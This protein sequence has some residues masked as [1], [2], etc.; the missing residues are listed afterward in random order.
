MYTAANMTNQVCESLCEGYSYYGTEYSTECFCGDSISNGANH[1]PNSACDMACGGDS[2]QI[3]G[4]TSLLS[5][6]KSDFNFTTQA[7]LF[8]YTYLGCASEPD[9]SRALTDLV[10]VGL[11][12][13]NKCLV[14]CSYGG[15]AYAGMEYGREC[16]CGHTLGDNVSMNGTCNMPCAG[17]A[18]ETCGGQLSLDLYQNAT[19]QILNGTDSKG[20]P[21]NL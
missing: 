12:T 5:I 20:L 17:N 16:W 10:S 13:R 15:Y 8:N 7:P 19:S 11:L 14:I 3:C 1:V 21:C 18:S 9:D 6:Y 4:G 2:T